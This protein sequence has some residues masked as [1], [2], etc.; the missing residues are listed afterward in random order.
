MVSDMW[1]LLQRE[2]RW[3]LMG[4]FRYVHWS[5]VFERRYHKEPKCD[6]C[7]LLDKYIVRNSYE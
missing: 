2:H 5:R 1:E 7:I 6:V 4:R 3:R